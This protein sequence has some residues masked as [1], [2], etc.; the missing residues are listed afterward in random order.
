MRDRFPGYEP[1]AQIPD[2]LDKDAVALAE[3]MSAQ[4]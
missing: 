1:V 4:R 3:E 2:L